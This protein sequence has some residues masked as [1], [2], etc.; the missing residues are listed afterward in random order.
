MPYQLARPAAGFRSSYRR[1]PDDLPSA[2][3][4]TAC[5][6]GVARVRSFN[7]NGRLDRQAMGLYEPRALRSSTR[8]PVRRNA[9]GNAT[10]VDTGNPGPA[11]KGPV[12]DV[13]LKAAGQA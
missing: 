1:V 2:S 3:E 11:L 12:R 10:S 4:V 7:R 13:M 8:R 6:P 9:S 5:A